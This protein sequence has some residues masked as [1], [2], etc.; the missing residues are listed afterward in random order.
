MSLY[1]PGNQECWVQINFNHCCSVEHRVAASVGFVW[2]DHISSNHL[3]VTLVSFCFK[4]QFMHVR[5]MW[6]VNKQCLGSGSLPSCTV[7]T[8]ISS[9]PFRAGFSFHSLS[10]SCILLPIE[11]NT[12]SAAVALVM[13]SRLQRVHFV[14]KVTNHDICHSQQTAGIN[15]NCKTKT[16]STKSKNTTPSGFS[17]F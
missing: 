8:V 4:N 15:N 1:V 11:I 2:P 13:E 6:I 14:S 16:N 10:F 7:L 3:A 5:F 9:L 12:A 17:H